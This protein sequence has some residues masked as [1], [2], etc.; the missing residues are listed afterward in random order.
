MR[1][2]AAGFVLGLLVG[3]SP[4]LA[5]ASRPDPAVATLPD[6][7]TAPAAVFVDEV[8]AAPEEDDEQYTLDIDDVSLQQADC[9]ISIMKQAGVEIT[10]ESVFALYDWAEAA[11]GSVCDYRGAE[12][13]G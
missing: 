10:V 8:A 11:Y 13:N 5:G 2:A 4:L 7:L 6:H 12:W 3:A 9:A 1:R